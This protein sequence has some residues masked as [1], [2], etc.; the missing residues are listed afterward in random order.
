[1]DEETQKRHLAAKFELYAGMAFS[2]AEA[3][4]LEICLA[5]LLW[6]CC[7]SLGLR[8]HA[9]GNAD[10]LLVSSTT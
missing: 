10:P 3:V 2:G 5:W 4:R 7:V 6:G 9:Q 8:R 1:M